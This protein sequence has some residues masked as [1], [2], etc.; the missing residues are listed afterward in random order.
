MLAFMVFY[1]DKGTAILLP[2]SKYDDIKVVGNLHEI[3]ELLTYRAPMPGAPM[4]T[5]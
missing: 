1:A 2:K 5:S 3:P 4:T